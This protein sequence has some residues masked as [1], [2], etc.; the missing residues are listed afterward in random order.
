MHSAT[1]ISAAELIDKI[2]PG[3][4]GFFVLKFNKILIIY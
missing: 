3:S 4:P 1:E 2:K